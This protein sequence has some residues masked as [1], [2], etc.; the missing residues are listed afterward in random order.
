MEPLINQLKSMKTQIDDLMQRMDMDGKQT[1][2]AALEEQSTANAFW[3][4]PT[5]AQKIMQQIAGLRSQIERWQGLAGRINDALEL[6]ALG[7]T[8]LEADIQQEVTDLEQVVSRLA[9]EAMF[10]G[11]YDRANTILAIHA[12]AGGTDAQDWAAMLERMFL[13]W[14]EEHRYQ[15][16]IMEKSYGDEAGLKSVTISIKGDYAYGYLK[17]EQGV[18]RLVRISPFNSS[19]TRETS[20]AKVELWPDIEGNI[21]IEI[22]EK[23]LRIDTYRSSGPGGQNVQKNDTAV[24]ITHLPSGIVVAS[25]T[26]RSQLQNRERAMQVL[27]S[28]LFE[29]ERQKHEAEIAALKGDNVDAGWGNQIRSYVLHPYQLVKD[30]RTGHETGNTTA[31]LNGEIDG[32]MEAYLRSRIAR[33]GKG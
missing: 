29:M 31:V 8:S 30:H 22:N 18:H 17:S 15:V 11:E 32:F 4:N 6:A 33:N 16:D 9:V 13:R 28:R 12:G 27:K 20:F 19:G 3:N 5:E 24:R 25:Q 10:T 26:Q 14:L 23:D 2:V 7:D 21:D 1:T